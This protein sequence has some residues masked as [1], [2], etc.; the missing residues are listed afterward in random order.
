MKA[1]EYFY[2]EEL[3]HRTRELEKKTEEA[4]RAAEKIDYANWVIAVDGLEW[5]MGEA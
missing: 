4:I 5:L 3:W 1:D 2:L